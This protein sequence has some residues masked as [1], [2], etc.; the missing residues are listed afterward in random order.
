MKQKAK[1]KAK[2]KANMTMQTKVIDNSNESITL[3][4]IKKKKAK[5]KAIM[6]MQTKVIEATAWHAYRLLLY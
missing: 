1:M 6:T 5:A 4:T 3:D 2:P